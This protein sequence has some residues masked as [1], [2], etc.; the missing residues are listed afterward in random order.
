MKRAAKPSAALSEPQKAALISLL[1]DDDESIYDTIRSKLISYGSEVSDWLR[2]HLLSSDP[3]LRR[4]AQEI[5]DHFARQNADTEFLSFCLRQGEDFDIEQGLWLLTKTHYP[6]ANTAAYSALL[7]SYAVD[8]RGKLYPKSS[9]ETILA[10]INE[11][12][13]DD[14]GLKGNEENYYD[15]EN[16]Y[17][18]RVLDRRTG[19]PISLSLIYMLIG[20]RLKLPVAGIGLPGHFVCRFQSSTDEFYIDAF[21]RGK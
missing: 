21:N 6:N 3:V 11:F 9:A 15:P 2:P 10:T 12:L 7:D 17:L 5:V 13:F 16:S 19:N 14:L 20:R 18:N 4:H 8:L 1:G